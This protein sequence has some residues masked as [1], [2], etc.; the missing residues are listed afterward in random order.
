MAHVTVPN[1]PR[2]T[3][4]S[5]GSTATT[6]PFAFSFTVFDKSDLRV[7]VDGTELGSGDF[8]FA[9]TAGY[10]GGFPGGSIS[11]I[12]SVSNAEVKIWADTLALRTDDIIPGNPNQVRD[13]NTTL[14]RLTVQA[15]ELRR[16]MA[17]ALRYPIGASIPALMDGVAGQ[18]FGPDGAGGVR[19]F[20]P[21]GSG[22]VLAVDNLS[23]VADAA[24]AFDNLIA[25][26][27]IVPELTDFEFLNLAGPSIMVY[28]DVN[29]VPGVTENVVISAVNDAHAIGC[30]EVVISYVE[31]QGYWFF[32]PTIRFKAGSVGLTFGATSG[33]AV[34]VVASAAFFD[35]ADVGSLLCRRINNTLFRA[36]ILSVADSTNATVAIL[37]SGGTVA[38][39]ISAFVQ[40]V[41]SIPGDGV[42]SH[43]LASATWT[44]G[45]WELRYFPWDYQTSRFGF[46]WREP[47]NTAYALT[48]P[49]GGVEDFSPVQSVLT[50]ANQ[51]GMKVYIGTGRS[52]DVPLLNDIVT[53][54]RRAGSAVPNYSLPITGATNANPC[55]VTYS[56]AID[57]QNGDA[58]HISGIVTGSGSGAF[59]SPAFMTVANVDPSAKTFELSGVDTSATGIWGVY[60][61]GGTAQWQN[62]PGSHLFS[63]ASNITAA[64]GQPALTSARWTET[65][66]QSNITTFVDGLYQG[67]EVFERNGSGRAIIRDFIDASNVSAVIV[68]PFSSASISSQNWTTRDVSSSSFRSG[69]SVLNR[70]FDTIK[71]IQAVCGDLNTQF[72][73]NAAFE[74][75]YISH[76]PDHTVRPSRDFF[77]PLINRPFGNAALSTY[78]VEI[79]VAPAS[80][81]DTPDF[82]HAPIV[83]DVAR[84][85]PVVVTSAG[86]SFQRGDQIQLDYLTGP[87]AALN[88]IPLYVGDCTTAGF[89]LYSNAELTTPVNT[90]GYSAAYSSD[91]GK[92]FML[93]PYIAQAMADSGITVFALQDS[94]GYGAN[95]AT[96]SYDY[97]LA[98]AT[99]LLQLDL[100]F[101][102]FRLLVKL[103]NDITPGIQ[104]WSWNELW[105]INDIIAG[106]ELAPIPASFARVREQIYRTRE[107]ADK[108][109]L[110]AL[111][112][113]A[114]SGNANRTLRDENGGIFNYGSRARRLFSGIKNQGFHKV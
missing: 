110:Y 42:S 103:A 48:V 83:S 37:N 45:E 35:A 57:P 105:Q 3:S 44:A 78:A 53:I 31:I 112:S 47:A 94:L 100:H 17:S 104:F 30:T 13:I 58:V 41:T 97:A 23:D 10:E 101:G 1:L 38:A 22:D 40:G 75:F 72:G 56:G 95:F 93:P 114:E 2:Y 98:T 8:T 43:P 76:E 90:S 84:A 14:D 20:T 59:T 9:G 19:T 24:T 5:V 77:E 65:R 96:A 4:F 69:W 106:V 102:A 39:N 55:V 46:Y 12:S 89:S 109:C 11:L 91:G 71:T 54:A 7:S 34:S 68:D 88:K 82:W 87:F 81:V 21:S 67:K 80:P 111:M 85:S 16:D 113:Y 18:A 49:A 15:Q 107:F 25:P 61:S 86:H 108:T 50:R 27:A 51:L 99:T 62:L 70:A 64:A 60:A 36:V 29:G 79:I 33:A 73:F 28:E 63:P 74:G 92:I 66:I 26:R 52:G 32:Q 6:G